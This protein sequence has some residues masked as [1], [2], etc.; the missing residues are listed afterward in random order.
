MALEKRSPADDE[1]R[2]HTASLACRAQMVRGQ[3][4]IAGGALGACR[5]LLDAMDEPTRES[6]QA[7]VDELSAELEAAQ[8]AVHAPA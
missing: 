6:C 8:A 7:S 1:A 3:F 2:F 5:K 4:K